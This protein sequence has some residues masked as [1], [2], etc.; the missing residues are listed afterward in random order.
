MEFV[1]VLASIA[2]TAEGYVF[3]NELH[4]HWGLMV[5]LYP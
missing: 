4:V 1:H 3:P 5:V 2:T